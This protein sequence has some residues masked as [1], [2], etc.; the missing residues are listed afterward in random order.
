MN[1][2]RIYIKRVALS[3]LVG[4][5]FG[6]AVTEIPVF[7][8]YKT[9]RAPREIVLTIPKGTAEQVQRGEQPPTIPQ[10]MIF[11]VGDVLTVKNEDVTDH[12]L[13]E[14]WV[15]ANSSAS[16]SLDQPADLLFECSFQPDE[17]FGIDV[18]KP[19][20]LATHILGILGPAV[21]LGILLALYSLALPVEK[22]EH[23][24]A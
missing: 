1:P 22:K 9:A 16:L 5:L 18:R 19:L 21:S 2:R 11:V 24:S 7:L 14:L 13:G 23:A 10:N 17:Y 3:L 6:V 12:R 8:L 15:P 4:L 20:T